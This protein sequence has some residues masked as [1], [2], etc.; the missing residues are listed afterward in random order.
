MEHLVAEGGGVFKAGVFGGAHHVGLEHADQDL[1]VDEGVGCFGG[2]FG[3]TAGFEFGVDASSD[4][5]DD[6]GGGD[7]VCCVVGELFFSSA[8]RFGHG[9]VHAVG[10][11]IGVEDD[12]GLSVASGSAHLLDERSRR[13]EKSFFV[14]VEDADQSHFWEVEAF[15]EEVDAYED[16]ELAGAEVGEDFESVEG[17]DFGVEVADA[18]ALVAQVGRQVFAESLGQCGD[19]DSATEFDDFFAAFDEVGDLTVGG[20]DFD[21]WV[22]ESG[23]SDDLFDDFAV[24]GLKFVW[25]WRC[26]DE[27]HL[28]DECFEL[29]EAER[30]VVQA[31]GEAEAVFDEDFFAGEVAVEHG[32]DLWD[33]HMGFIDD[34]EPVF[35]ICS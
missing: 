8:C 1:G 4:V 27:H 13:A 17:F 10:D 35:E 34:D 29:F 19:E 28:G 15:A 2:V 20:A 26:A 11:A 6:G 32:A 18:H 7:V 3:R 16:V 33:G 24:G 12:A 21:F 5:L 30:A 31:G 9:L 14:G 25:A 22:E 23:G